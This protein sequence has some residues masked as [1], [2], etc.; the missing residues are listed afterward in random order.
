MFIVRCLSALHGSK[1]PKFNLPLKALTDRKSKVKRLEVFGDLLKGTIE[2]SLRC[3][4]DVFMTWL[5]KR[6]YF[7]IFEVLVLTCQSKHCM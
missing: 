3:K 2:I 6:L 1:F 5:N 7:N 4:Y